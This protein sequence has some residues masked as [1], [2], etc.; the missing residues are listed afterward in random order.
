[1]P[2]AAL[3]GAEV[4]CGDLRVLDDAGVA[5]LRAAW[6]DNLVIV[7]RDQTLSDPEL[8]A[9]GR[10]LGELDSAPKLNEPMS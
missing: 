8:M 5:A 3:L 1:M 2:T 6:L 9:F 10:R 4:Q 7:V